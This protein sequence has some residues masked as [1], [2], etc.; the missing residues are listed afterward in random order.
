MGRYLECEIGYT[1]EDT[2]GEMSRFSRRPPHQRRLRRVRLGWHMAAATFSSI[3]ARVG[4][5]RRARTRTE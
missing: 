3:M 1:A 2:R 5:D 4:E